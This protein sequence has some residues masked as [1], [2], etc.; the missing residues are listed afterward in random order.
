MTTTGCPQE[1][2]KESLLSFGG[3]G[4][5]LSWALIRIC[6]RVGEASFPNHTV[7]PSKVYFS[8]S[9]RAVQASPRSCAGTVAAPQNALP[10]EFSPPPHLLP[11]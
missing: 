10:P 1:V 5:L 2:C 6:N 9:L 4:L 7:P 3:P 11:A 8:V